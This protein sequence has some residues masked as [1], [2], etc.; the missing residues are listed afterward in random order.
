LIG[1]SYSVA[2]IE[3]VL[4]PLGFDVAAEGE[5]LTA[6]VPT[7]RED[8]EGRA[9]IAEEVARISGYDA[10]PVA[11]PSGQLPRAAEDAVLRWEESV[12]TA[13]AAAGLQ[14]VKTYSLVE[15]NANGKLQADSPQPV[16]PDSDTV[17]VYNPISIEQSRLRTTLLPSLLNTVGANLRFQD[18]VFVFETA[19][20][21]LPPLDPLPREARRLGIAMAGRRY[22]AS[23]G[24]DP[25][26]A[27]FFDL[28]AAVES[29]FA[30]LHLPAPQV[31]PASAS[32]LHPGRAAAVRAANGDALGHMGQVHPRVAERFDIDGVE[33]YAAELKLDLLLALAQDEVS[34]QPLP[35]YPAVTRDL[36]LIVRDEIGHE[37]LAD[38]IR[39]AGGPLLESVELFDVYRGSPV[40]D[41]H[42]SLAYSLTFRSPERTLTEDEIGAAMRSIEA[43]V[44]SRFGAQIRGR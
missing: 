21:Y 25:T 43:A 40:P 36:A 18:R 7:W 13:L 17:A 28:K 4:R 20:V 12:Q 27:D 23:W 15:P 1:Q 41:G 3:R 29:A 14:E 30:A 37:V 19:R 8:V 34:V 24:S 22:P 2:E 42:R 5:Q 44:T 35:R 10:I 33:V 32:W 16:S 11:L 38:A 39:G 9:D 26:P 6:V 31:E